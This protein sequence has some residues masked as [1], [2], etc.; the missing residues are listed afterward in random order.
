MARAECHA[1]HHCPAAAATLSKPR[2][3]H[4][5]GHSAPA[6]RGAWEVPSVVAV[7]AGPCL[8]SPEKMT[9]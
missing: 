6:P 2:V 1:G 4:R 8:L 3:G 5:T 7:M 9:V